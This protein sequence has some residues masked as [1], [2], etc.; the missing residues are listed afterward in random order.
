[1]T[2][3]S[4]DELRSLRDNA[5]PPCVT[6]YMPTHRGGYDSQ[7]D[8]IRYKNLLRHAEE[9]LMATGA[10]RGDCD[11]ILASARRLVDDATFWQSPTERGEAMVLFAA[12]GTVR[13][14]RLPETVRELVIVND[15]FHFGPLLA[16]VESEQR[17]HVLALSKKSVRLVEADRESA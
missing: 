2:L 14:L 4:R 16:S 13:H 9:Q 11:Q 8:P 1:M 17:F 12:R 15:R 10:S 7:Q 6:L 3:P 5:T